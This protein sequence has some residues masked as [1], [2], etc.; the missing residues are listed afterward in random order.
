MKDEIIENPIPISVQELLKV[1]KEDLSAVAFPD[2]SFKVLEA[3]SQDV[4]KNAKELA[5]TR[6]LAKAAEEALDASQNELLQKSLRAIAY[7]KVFAEDKS[8]LLDKLSQINLG[9]AGRSAKKVVGEKPKADEADV[10]E[11]AERKNAKA[12]KKSEQKPEDELSAS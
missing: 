2:V 10:L 8:E 6:E 7:A 4:E 9:K 12:A 1:F 3:L 11:K 5:K